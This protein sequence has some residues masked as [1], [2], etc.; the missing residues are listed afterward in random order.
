MRDI[1]AQIGLTDKGRVIK[2]LVDCNGWD[3]HPLDLLNGLA[4]STVP[5]NMNLTKYDSKTI[6]LT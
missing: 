6:T 5:C 3:L 1:N 2:G 4:L